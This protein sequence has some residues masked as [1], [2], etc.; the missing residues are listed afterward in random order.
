MGTKTDLPHLEHILLLAQTLK[1]RKDTIIIAAGL[2]NRKKRLNIATSL[3]YQQLLSKLGI[4]APLSLDWGGPTRK[5][6]QG[7]RLQHFA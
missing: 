1:L 7:H 3:T 4:D 6:V 5:L 2:T